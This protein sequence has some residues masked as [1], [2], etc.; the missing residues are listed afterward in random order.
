D[1][2]VEGNLGGTVV[3]TPWRRSVT[4]KARTHTIRTGTRLTLHG[5]V[6]W[7]SPGPRGARLFP[8][9]VLAR[10]DSKHPFER[11]ATVPL[12]WGR[13]YLNRWNHAVHASE[14]TTYIAKVTGQLPQGQIWANAT[15]RP[16]TVRVQQ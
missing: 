8:V 2:R 16:F 5:R 3:A 14:T 12:R 1:Y 10:H 6:N 15:S 4:L 7:K 11:I 9:I 13:T